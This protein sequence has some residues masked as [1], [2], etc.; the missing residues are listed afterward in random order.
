MADVGG[1]V[2]YPVHFS[3]RKHLAE[4]FPLAIGFVIL[5]YVYQET[6]YG[7][8]AAVVFS[9]FFLRMSLAELKYQWGYEDWKR[10][11]GEKITLNIFLT[12]FWVILV[13]CFG[14]F[15]VGNSV[16]FFIDYEIVPR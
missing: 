7:R 2:K 5:S 3:E 1:G 14:F 15:L 9:W 8:L 12:V 11:I 4:Y 6:F 13:L 10:Q 16:M